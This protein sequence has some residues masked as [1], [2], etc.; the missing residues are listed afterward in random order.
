[1]FD[2]YL[3]F[4]RELFT[5]L[6]NGKHSSQAPCNLYFQSLFTLSEKSFYTPSRLTNIWVIGDS[7]LYCAD[8]YLLAFAESQG[9]IGI[10][11]RTWSVEKT[12]MLRPPIIGSEAWLLTERSETSL[13]SR[14][15]EVSMGFNGMK[16]AI[17]HD[18]PAL[19]RSL[20]VPLV[21]QVYANG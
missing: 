18:K 10:L 5:S 1:M 11:S 13:A 8:T 6:K 17:I 19:K 7:V 16:L 21:R 14:C 15:C 9:L 4:S 2:T 3:P 20:F 12:S